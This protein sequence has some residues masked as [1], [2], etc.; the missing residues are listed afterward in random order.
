MISKHRTAQDDGSESNAGHGYGHFEDAR[1]VGLDSETEKPGKDTFDNPR[2]L[3]HSK[4][5]SWARRIASF[6][7]LADGRLVRCTKSHLLFL[8]WP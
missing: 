8:G 5:L 3:S 7:L 6:R 4:D 1:M 2:Y